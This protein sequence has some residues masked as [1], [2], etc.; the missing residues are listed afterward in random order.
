MRVHGLLV[1]IL[2]VDQHGLRISVDVMRNIAYASR[3][4]AGG[5]G[6]IAQDFGD[7]IAIIFRELH[8]DCKA[9][10]KSVRSFAPSGNCN[11]QRMIRTGPAL[12]FPEEVF[13]G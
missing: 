7:A 2:L 10:H 1:T 5:E 9:H 3:F 13:K 12:A 6:E 11:K 8:A 4:L